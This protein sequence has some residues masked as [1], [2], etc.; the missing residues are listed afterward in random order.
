MLRRMMKSKFGEKFDGRFHSFED[1]DRA[2]EWCEN[3]LLEK[4][5]DTIFVKGALKVE[6]Y[7][8]LR[9]LTPAELEIIRPLLRSHSFKSG[10]KVITA[11]AA[12][13]EIFFLARGTV[14]VYLH[15]G[16]NQRLATFSPG[17]CFGEM[18][19]IDGAPRSA[20]IIADTD[21]ECHSLGLD[22]YTA[23]GESRPALKIKL[24]EQLCRDL[25]RKLRKANRELDVLD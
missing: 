9:A 20:D 14:S 24:L 7:E 6:D 8:L 12:A 5:G 19:F 13:R 15:G 17:M 3:Q 1:N 2:L 22:D 23:L 11:G 4:H 16:E 25:T 10:H 18:A 21:V